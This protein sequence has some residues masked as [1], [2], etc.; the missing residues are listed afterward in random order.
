MATLL[1]DDTTP[2]I[3]YTA[4]A[5]QTAF[6][7]PYTF[8]ANADLQVTVNGTTKALN[9][10]YSVT[11]AQVT[12]G[13]TLT[14]AS[15]LAV[16][17]AVVIERVLTIERITNFPNSGPFSIPDLNLEFDRE[18]AMMQQI[19]LAGADAQAAD[20]QAIADAV[21][22]LQSASGGATATNFFTTR[23]AAALATISALTSY[24]RTAGYA[25]AGDRGGA[26]YM[27]NTVTTFGGFQ[28][29]DGAWW[30]L[31]EPEFSALMFGAK[32]DLVT[33]DTSALQAWLNA[34]TAYNRP[35]YLP[36][37]PTFGY[38]IS[39]QLTV[40][41]AVNLVIRGDG[42]YVGST[43]FQSSTTANGLVV[44]ITGRL[45]LDNF[46]IR[47]L[48][49]P[50]AGSMVYVVGSTGG[51]LRRLSIQFCY[52]GV[53]GIDWLGLTVTECDIAPINLGMAL[54]SPGDSEI[55]NNRF[56]PAA[57]TASGITVSGNPGGT[58]ILSNK[59]NSGT[60]YAY[61][62][63]VVASITDGDFFIIGN[64][65]EAVQG[66]GISV[67]HVGSA[68]FGNL[69][70]EGNQL[71]V[72]GRAIDLPDTTSG[73]I[74]RVQITGNNLYST[75]GVRVN[76]AT[77]LIISDNIIDGGGGITLGANCITGTIHDN[78]LMAGTIA[79]SST[80]VRV[81]DNPGYNPVGATV[82]TAGAS[83]WTYLA[84]ASPETLIISASTSITQVSPQGTNMLAAA[85]GANVALTI[86]LGP[87]EGVTVSYTGTLSVGRVIH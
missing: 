61:G 65:I 64:S 56:S 23:G 60:P 39:S 8:F 12:G 50:S 6:T 44:S 73:W 20:A 11:G 75:L 54:Q 87:F 32:G 18:V 62:I 31:A 10:D 52:N 63:G 59:I 53:T 7:V 82:V 36:P 68:Q 4:T 35:G 76:A 47:N 28:S 80:T 49:T 16:N 69:I 84:G 78:T 67:A 21:A 19:A 46:G 2:R 55:H 40:T 74:T 27:R 24:L 85:L 30:K 45:Y 33:D 22:L 15:G 41:G 26:I 71:V 57:A 77:G 43:I 29:A 86:V 13:G 66:T 1:V 70:I 37:S 72:A 14:F 38:L 79:S 3:A 42:S 9:T 17:D 51:F 5:G 81:H 25:A 34:C 48:T 83:P 58:R